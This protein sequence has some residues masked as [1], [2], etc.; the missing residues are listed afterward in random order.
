MEINNKTLSFKCKFCVK[1]EKAAWKKGILSGE[2]RM[3]AASSQ[4]IIN[5]QKIIGLPSRVTFPAFLLAP[6]S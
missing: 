5:K 2:I 6:F 3:F 1:S 4:P